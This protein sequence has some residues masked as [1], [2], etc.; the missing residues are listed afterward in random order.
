MRL[1][2]A[3]IL[4]GGPGSGRHKGVGFTGTQKGMTPAQ[5]TTLRSVLEH[6]KEKGF[7]H[8]HHGDAIGADAQAHKIAKSV[9]YKIVLHPPDDDSKRAFTKG[10]EERE[11]KHYYKRNEDIV[12]ESKT[13][14]ATPRSV[15]EQRRS[16]TWMTVRRADNAGRPYRIIEPSGKVRK[17]K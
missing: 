15:N 7:T 17:T 3:A 1:A 13:L 10:H 12:N 6:L 5:A 11:P 14:I 8:F 16:G 2:T 4:A 9:G